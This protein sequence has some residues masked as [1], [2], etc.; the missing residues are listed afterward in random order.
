MEEC[1][2]RKERREIDRHSE[3]ENTE[4]RKKR[5]YIF[6]DVL[7]TYIFFVSV[8]HVSLSCIVSCLFSVSL[9]LHIVSIKV[10]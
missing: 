7:F 10:N 3:S 8:F 1:K 2:E 9:L 4:R 6:I 5:V